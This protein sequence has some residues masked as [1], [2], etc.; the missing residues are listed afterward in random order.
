[1]LLEIES[2]P[3]L[4]TRG[5]RLID[6]YPDNLSMKAIEIDPKRKKIFIDF[7]ERIGM[8][9]FLENKMQNWIQINDCPLRGALRS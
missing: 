8:M 6:M 9:K 4:K 7:L 3:L 5:D 1:M 2:I